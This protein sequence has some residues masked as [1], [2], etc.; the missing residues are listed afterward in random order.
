[1]G[2]MNYD[3]ET[4]RARVLAMGKNERD[5]LRDRLERG[6]VEARCTRCD[7][8]V[9]TTDEL[10]GLE[11]QRVGTRQGGTRELFHKGHFGHKVEVKRVA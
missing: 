4:P 2:Y 1:M 5:A 9:L 8:K 6:E 10:V 7:G 3:K 11:A